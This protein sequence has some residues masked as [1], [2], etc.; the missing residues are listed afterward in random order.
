MVRD[1]I[2]EKEKRVKCIEIEFHDKR[3]L[4]QEIY[5]PE[6]SVLNVCVPCQ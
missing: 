1:T 3:L 2:G 4:L 5:E 6:I